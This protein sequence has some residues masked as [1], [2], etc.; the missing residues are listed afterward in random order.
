M[1]EQN[2]REVEVFQN[3]IVG[4]RARMATMSAGS[5]SVSGSGAG[6]GAGAGNG[7]GGGGKPAA[8]S[9]GRG[10]N[11][12]AARENELL[13]HAAVL[14]NEKKLPA[15]VDA[16]RQ[17]LSLPKPFVTPQ[18][19]AVVN[20]RLGMSLTALG[21]VQPAIDAYTAAIAA[22][23]STIEHNAYNNRGNLRRQS[24]LYELAI[25]DFTRAIELNNEDATV[26]WNRAL[27]YEARQQWS[28]A[29]N[30]HELGLAF[31]QNPVC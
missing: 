1:F 28:D 13:Q 9:N 18:L 6:A 25:S 16:L 31:E 30:D 20:F 2:P 8:A 29:L 12:A 24:E 27:C 10:N 22:S 17:I 21:Q 5:G 26:F 19:E 7:A 11:G 4:I 23:P 14:Y 15:A 3:Q